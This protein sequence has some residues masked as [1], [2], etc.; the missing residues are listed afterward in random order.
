MS[1][2]EPGETAISQGSVAI[3]QIFYNQQTE[4]AR[5]E[6]F[7]PLDC[8]SDPAPERREIHH[9]LAFF[10]A[11]RHY[12]SDY[13]GIVS[14]KFREKAKI[15]GNHFINFINENPGADVYFINPYPHLSYFCFNLWDQGELVSPG[16][17]DLANQVF[18]A[19]GY[20]I[21]V[22]KLPRNRTD[23][24]LYC[25]FWVG[26]RRFWDLFMPFVDGLVA[27]LDRLPEAVQGRIFGP[28]PYLTEATYFPFI[29]ERMFSTFLA[30]HPEVVAKPFHNCPADFE[31]YYFS[32]M[33]RLLIAE[34]GTMI[35]G[36]DQ[37]GVYD[38]DRRQI[39][40]SL[41][42]IVYLF[43]GVK[44]EKSQQE[45]LRQSAQETSAIDCSYK[46]TKRNALVVAHYHEQG[47][48]AQ[49]LID[50]ISDY[51]AAGNEVVFVSTNASEKY[52]DKLPADITVIQ[53]ENSGYDFLSYKIGIAALTDIQDFEHL[54]IINSSF[55]ILDADRLHQNYF[56]KLGAA[57]D[58]FALTASKEITPHL[59]SYLISFSQKVL[60]S[61]AFPQWWDGVGTISERAEVIAKYELGMSQYFTDLGFSVGAAFAPD[62]RQRLL[63]IAR[64]MD[65][66]FFNPDI[67]PDGQV[68]LD[69]R[70][71]DW[72]NPT[73]FLWDALLDS[74]GI[75]K[76]ETLRNP[77][78]LGED[79][80]RSRLEGN[81]AFKS[82]LVELMG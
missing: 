14:P 41:M 13:S 39:F 6:A 60:R 59:Q 31:P 55:L 71:A 25:N 61:G 7:L 67:S 33:E 68:A 21:D 70:T 65:C 56:Q 30:L 16:L 32:D 80:A 15:T 4:A 1:S 45:L 8:R 53:R 34:W 58:L 44:Y 76:L 12:H 27:A 66:G 54:T 2:F 40:S 62:D 20:D 19:A 57:P 5:D 22:R 77:F 69:I 50:F 72:L 43:N 49:G 64:A 81:P 42:K 28:A 9:I 47:V 75:V 24:A 29:F 11:Q 36:W 35:D 48:I 78:R 74:C 51:Y 37:S 38:A 73:H 52:I 23:T 10:K 18:A 17:C 63:A 3:Y 79:S 26:S 46:V 82:A